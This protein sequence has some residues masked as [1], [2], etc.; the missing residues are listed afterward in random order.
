MDLHKMCSSVGAVTFK[1]SDQ[2]REQLFPLYKV[3][4]KDFMVRQTLWCTSGFL[5]DI[6]VAFMES[7][8]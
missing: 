6:N 2:S 4:R 5:L 8:K 7:S 3:N 1:L